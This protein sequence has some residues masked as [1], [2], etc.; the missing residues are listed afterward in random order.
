MDGDANSYGLLFRNCVDF[1]RK[2]AEFAGLGT[3]ISEMIQWVDTPVNH[4][5]SITDWLRGNGFGD[6]L[7]GI[8]WAVGGLGEL[9]EMGMDAAGRAWDWAVGVG[10]SAYDWVSDIGDQ[11]GGF[12]SDLWGQITSFFGGIFGDGSPG[13]T[14]GGDSETHGRSFTSD[15]DFIITGEDSLAF[16]N[17]YSVSNSDGRF[18][19]AYGIEANHPDK[20][21][22][23]VIAPGGFTP[24]PWVF[25]TQQITPSHS[26]WS[27]L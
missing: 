11:I 7:D 13:G 16:D 21:F 6:I 8:G 27:I 2:V 23:Y 14:G 4:Y 25:D 15:D 10:R 12:A 17:A 22:D 19:G 20:S 18:E 5:A 3:D 9:G 24:E 1:V 26:D